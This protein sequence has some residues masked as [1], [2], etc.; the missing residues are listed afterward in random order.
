MTAFFDHTVSELMT[1]TPAVTSPDTSLLDA[2][3]KMLELGVSCLVVDL[4]E[5]AR[6]F[7]I[8]THKDTVS[9]LGSETESPKDALAD[10]TVG[11]V[12]TAPAV[13]VPPG[14]RLGT[15]LDL[16]RML[17]VRRAPVLEGGELLGIISITDIFKAALGVAL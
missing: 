11:D 17:G 9:L 5:P 6:G 13:T 3:A 12:M 2:G 15:C 10:V 4:G 16:M 7:G 1:A 14:Y 8:V